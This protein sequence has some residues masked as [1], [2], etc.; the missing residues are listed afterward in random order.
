MS[1]IKGHLERGEVPP[2]IVDKLITKTY[3]AIVESGR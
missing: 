3:Y 2:P 1:E